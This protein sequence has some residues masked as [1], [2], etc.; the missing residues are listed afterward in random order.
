MVLDIEDLDHMET[1]TDLLPV[2]ITGL[3]SFMT[4]FRI[5]ILKCK[6]EPRLEF[7][8]FNNKTKQEALLGKKFMVDKRYALVSDTGQVK[9]TS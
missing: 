2:H 5:E 7:T 3:V 1:S 9:V 8:L 6:T 4:V